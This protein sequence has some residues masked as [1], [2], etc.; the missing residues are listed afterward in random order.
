M[1]LGVTGALGSGKDTVG[2]YLVQNYGFRR[3]GFADLL[4][5]SAG[6]LFDVDPGAW[7]DWKNREDVRVEIRHAGTIR[8][9]SARQ[10]LQRYGTEAHRDVFGY[11]FWVEQALKFYEP[12]DFGKYV[13]TDVRFENEAKAIQERGGYVIRVHRPGTGGD[14]HASERPLPASLTDIE[15]NNNGTLDDLYQLIDETMKEC[16]SL[17]PVQESQ[18]VRQ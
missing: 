14:S 3:F 16:F 2:A 4:K 9:L 17:T 13:F 5:E 10:F 11:D 6:A 12:T 18:L 7:N 1:L 8:S 15:I